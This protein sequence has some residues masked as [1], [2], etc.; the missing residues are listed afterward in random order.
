M[1]KI[2]EENPEDKT[3]VVMRTETRWWSLVYSGDGQAMMFA[4][5]IMICSESTVQMEELQIKLHVCEWEED[6]AKHKEWTLTW[7]HEFKYLRATFQSNRHERWRKEA[8][9]SRYVKGV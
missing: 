6:V 1:Y 7:V 2:W 8:G 3:K 5:D 4:D 9:W